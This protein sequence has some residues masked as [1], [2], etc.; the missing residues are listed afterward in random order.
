MKIPKFGNKNTLFRYFWVKI[1]KKYCYILNQ[2][3]RISLIP[4]FREMVKM[5][6]FGT[7][8]ALFEYFWAWLLKEILSYLISEP[9]NALFSYFWARIF[10]KLLSHLKSAASHLSKC[11]ISW[12]NKGRC[13]DLGPKMPYLDIFGLKF[14]KTIVTFKS[15][16]LKF[17]K[18]E[19]LT[20]TG[21][22]G[23]ESIFS[24][25]LGSTF[26]RSVSGSVSRSAL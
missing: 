10:K 1:L 19:S 26:W 6:K 23:V 22:S 11:K 8:N 13:L 2:Y 16:S 24:K 21:N 20:Y 25:G 12:K 7:K 9:R 5:V 4:K 14:S 17:V 15:N 3:P 18:H